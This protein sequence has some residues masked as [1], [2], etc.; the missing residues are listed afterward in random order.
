[1]MCVVE[2]SFK[3]HLN[4]PAYAHFRAIWPVRDLRGHETPAHPGNL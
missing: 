1:M 3:G 4:G 2:L